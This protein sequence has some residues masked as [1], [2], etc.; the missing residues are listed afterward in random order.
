MKKTLIRKLSVS[1]KISIC[2][3]SSVDLKF[4]INAQHN[5]CTQGKKAGRK[6]SYEKGG[7]KR[8]EGE[9]S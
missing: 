3:F 1:L 7:L 9:A 8:G 5:L 6:L 4:Y 2:L